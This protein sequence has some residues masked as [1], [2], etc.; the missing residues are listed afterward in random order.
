MTS[1]SRKT[2]I[3]MALKLAIVESRKTARVIAMRTE[4]GEVRLSAIVNG[5]LQATDDE[6]EKLARVLKRQASELFPEVAA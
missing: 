5:R 4:I 6:K 3:N 1:D 2:Q